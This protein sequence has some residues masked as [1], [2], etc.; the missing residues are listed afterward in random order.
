LSASRYYP[1]KIPV[2]TQTSP[3]WIHNIGRKGSVYL[4]FSLG[5]QTE[6]KTSI[7]GQL[8]TEN[9]LVEAAT[10]GPISPGTGCRV[11]SW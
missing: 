7:E 4:V 9:T 1:V 5:Y 2:T 10:L 11:I 8:P 6:R 3:D